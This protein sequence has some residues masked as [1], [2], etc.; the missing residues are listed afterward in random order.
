MASEK[1]PM[2][3]T[4]R[5]LVGQMRQIGPNGVAFVDPG[6]L[7]DAE[8]ELV[9]PSAR[10][11]EDVLAACRHPLTHA[12]DPEHAQ[13]TRS[14]LEYAV[15]AAP[16]GHDHGDPQTGCVPTYYFWMRLRPES[17]PPVPMAGSIS[18]RIGQI[19]DVVMYFGNIGY[20]VYPPARGRQYAAR[21]CRLLFEL[22]RHHALHPLWITTDPAN[23]ASRRTCELLGG[24]LVDIVNLP[25]HHILYQRGQRQKCRYQIDLFPGQ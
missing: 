23:L 25:R 21:A 15:Q 18:L 13:T 10:W 9:P 5:S 3:N 16:H 12:D 11:I 4:R 1:A 6:P 2:T 14:Q 20:N 19:D 17:Y 7:I 8:L 22:A 24:T